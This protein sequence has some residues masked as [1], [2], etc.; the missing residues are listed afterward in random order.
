MTSNQ[1]VRS[2]NVVL[3]DNSKPDVEQTIN[4]LHSIRTCNIRTF[5]SVHGALQEIN[6][7]IPDVI[8]SELEVEDHSVEELLHV[9]NTYQK[10]RNIPVLV[11]TIFQSKQI[12]NKL[13]GLG[14]AGVLVKPADPKILAE[15]LEK[16]YPTDEEEA[17]I[18]MPQAAQSIQ[19][20]LRQIRDLAPLP[21]LAAEIIAISNNPKSTARDLALIIQKDQSLAA[22][23]LRIVNSAY[24]NFYRKISDVSRTIVIL[25]LLE[26]KNITL[27]ACLMQNFPTRRGPYFTPELY[28]RH[29]LG[30]AYITRS[31]AKLCKDLSPEDAFTMGLLH[32]FG[33]VIFDQ[34]FGAVFDVILREAAEKNQPL[35]QVEK[36]L[37]GIDHAVIGALVA[38]NWNLPKTLVHA[39]RYHHEPYISFSDRRVSFVHLA[40]YFCHKLKIGASGNPAP[41]ELHPGTLPALGIENKNIDEV[42]EMTGIDADAII[43]II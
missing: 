42:W 41:E 40:N 36:E 34:H 35:N 29:A 10:L 37:V 4:T 39:I 15:H 5:D 6:K 27:A 18:R 1:S 13:M 12:L 30:A 43:S 17:Q 22:R 32:D 2:L 3:L 23:L 20:H 24:Y 16:I 9:L 7:R 8:I 33:K 21:T 25:G 38:E 31:L 28:W 19:E 14:A 11:L 26:V